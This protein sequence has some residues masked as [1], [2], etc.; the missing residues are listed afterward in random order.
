MT[1]PSAGIGIQCIEILGSICAVNSLVAQGFKM[2]A[3]PSADELLRLARCLAASSTCM[4][5]LRT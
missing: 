2:P 4:T 1:D 5:R 3:L